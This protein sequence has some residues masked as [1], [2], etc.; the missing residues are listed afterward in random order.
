M[1]LV[2]WK[3]TCVSDTM[4]VTVDFPFKI[5][6]SPAEIDEKKANTKSHVHKLHMD[7]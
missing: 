7:E 6:H 2:I 4:D 1:Y 5:W 3:D